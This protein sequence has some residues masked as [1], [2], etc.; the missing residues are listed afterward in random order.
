MKIAIDFRE[1]AEQKHAGKGEYVWQLVK[2]MLA[3][4]V[5]ADLVL[6][7]YNWQTVDLPAGR[8]TQRKMGGRSLVW[9]LGVIWWLLFSHSVQVYFSTTSW[10]VP[11]LVWGVPVVTTIF[12]FT[13]WRYPETHR[14][15]TLF[16]ERLLG[17]RALQRSSQ[18]LA[19]S[20]FTKQ[21]AI[22]LFGVDGNKITVTPL[23]AD[24]SCQPLLLDHPSIETVRDRY[25]VPDKFILYLGTLEPRKNV[26][27]LVRAYQQA[28]PR[29]GEIKL[30]L[31]GARGWLAE[32]IMAVATDPAV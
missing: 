21:E 20:E 26:V 13:P 23:A 5:S 18:L 25:R 7:T 12:D 6:L 15:K 31:A 22:D 9:Q 8:W 16:W 11:A 10:I 3:E 1:A 19:I 14:A 4:G 2:A 29:L 17:R 30:V 32:Q 27:A 24:E 28:K